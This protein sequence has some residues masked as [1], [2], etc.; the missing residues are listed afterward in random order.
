MW[1]MRAFATGSQIVCTYRF[2]EPRSGAEMY[3][4]G[5]VGPDGVTP[6]F[7]GQQYT[8]AATEME[9]LRAQRDPTAKEPAEYS[10]RRTA[11]LYNFEDRWDVDNHKQTTRW[12][13][14]EH[15]LKQYRALKRLGCPTEIITED[16]DFNQY[17]FLVVPAYQ[18]VDEKLVQRWKDYAQNG[19]H[20]IITCR[21][22]QKDRRG[23]LWEGPWAMPILGLIGAKIAFYDTLPA[24]YVGKVRAG[25]QDYNWVSWAEVLQ[26]D[27]GTDVLAKYADQ[28]Y[29]GGAA[30]TTRDL[31]KGT[32]TYIGVDSQDGTLEAKLIHDVFQRAGVAVQH[33]DEGFLVDW[34][35]GFWVATNFTDKQQ[36]IPAAAGATMVLGARDIPPAGVAIWK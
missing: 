6:T 34:R 21:T 29:A 4:Y 22:G 32:V 27:N 23:F 24:P 18:L 7:G 35:D 12:D 16:K 36:E 5:L 13:T 26:P 15:V 28:Y 20:L 14:P 11:I 2:R 33:F 10:A 9:M 17:P 30:A 1:I 8:Q 31:G 25:D 19:G 3:H